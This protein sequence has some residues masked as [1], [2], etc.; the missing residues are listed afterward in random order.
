MTRSIPASLAG[1]I[2]QQVLAHLQDKSAHS[3]IAGVLTDAVKPLGDVQVFCPDYAAY[4]YVCVSTQG[5][6]FGLAVGMDTVAFRLDARMKSRAL[7]TGGVAYPECGDEWVAV[8]H[9][10]PDA[11]WPKVDV[12]FWA[13]KSYVYAREGR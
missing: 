1:S 9:R 2:N 4:R 3:D 5:I 13:R 10:L 12:A 7:A 6:I 8:V 11:D